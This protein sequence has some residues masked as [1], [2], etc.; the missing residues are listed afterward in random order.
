MSDNLVK[1]S[2]WSTVWMFTDTMASK[3]IAFV[4]GIILARLL[5]PSDFGIIGMMT[6]FTSLCDVM[7]ESGTSN[8]LIRKNDRNSAD[9]S[10]AFILNVSVAIGA[11]LLLFALSLPIANFYNEPI[12]ESLLKF[13][14]LNVILYALCIVPNALL[15]AKF[16]TKQQAKI[17]FLANFISGTTALIAALIGFGVWALV[18]QLLLSNSIKVIGYWLSA[19]WIPTMNWSRD[20][21]SYLWKYSSKSFFIG[22]LGTFFSNIYNLVVGKFYTKVDLG[23]FARA[24]QFVQLPST[25]ISSTYQRVSVATF[26]Q[27]QDNQAHLLNVYRKYIHVI[28]FISFSLFFFLAVIAKPLILILLTNKWIV[29][30]PMLTLISVG[31]AF[32]PLGIINICLLQAINKVDY[33]LKLEIKKKIVFVII[34]AASI[35]FGIFPMIIGSVIYNIAGTFMNMSCSYKF[36]NYKYVDQVKDIAKY[37]VAAAIAATISCLLPTAIGNEYILI[38]CETCS[39]AIIYLGVVFLMK[40]PVLNYIKELKQKVKNV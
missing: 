27:I 2:F 22:L 35:P 9:C 29:C 4:I 32:S 38:I 14:G 24:N 3:A 5:A 31:S 15:I 20:S 6:V 1:K 8:A 12:I 23:Y 37:M 34:L 19:K 18:L 36:L 28:S 30:A 25:I 21:F 7:I 10:T 33:L 26:A 11:Y 39:F 17:N 13:A 40:L 16:N